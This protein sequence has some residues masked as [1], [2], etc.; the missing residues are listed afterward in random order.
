MG[1]QSPRQRVVSHH[2]SRHGILFAQSE[3]EFE[4]LSRFIS[5][6]RRKWLIEQKELGFLTKST[7][8]GGALALSAA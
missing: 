2:H 3:Q 6:E 4:G 8:Q 7:G 1:R 5:I